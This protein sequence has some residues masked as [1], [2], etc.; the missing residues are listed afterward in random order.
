MCLKNK[1]AAAALC[2]LIAGVG[3][4]GVGGN[5]ALAQTGGANTDQAIAQ[6]MQMIESL[7]Q[8]IQQIIQLIAQLKPQETC[9]NGICRFGETATN[10][11]A[12]C[13]T[14]DNCIQE[15]KWGQQNQKCCQGL[16]ANYRPAVSSG[17]IDAQGL[18]ICHKCGDGICSENELP[19]FC[20]KDCD[21]NLNPVCGNKICEKGE[22]DFIS[23]P[24]YKGSC[25][26][27]CG[28]P[29]S[30]NGKAKC[31]ATGGVWKYLECMSGC[32]TPATK[33]D[34]LKLVDT[35]CAA[36]CLQGNG[37]ACPSGKTWASHEEGCIIYTPAVTCLSEGAV[38]ESNNAT[39]CCAGLS[40]INYCN[41]LG[42]CKNAVIC[43]AKCGDRICGSRENK[44]NCPKDCN[45]TGTACA[46]AGQKCEIYSTGTGGST[47][48]T[49]AQN[50]CCE[51]YYCSAT[52]MTCIKR[53]TCGNGTCEAGESA[54][55]CPADCKT[56]GLKNCAAFTDPLES[57][58][59]E[60]GNYCIEA[61]YPG[62]SCQNF[63]IE[64]PTYVKMASG[65][66]CSQGLPSNYSQTLVCYCTK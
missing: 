29:A 60:C 16:T 33:A 52:T 64:V 24:S 15:G 21:I 11:A 53:P 4:F 55:G 14:I 45:T 39:D 19:E 59:C 43:T 1:I 34:R 61:G 56:A 23:D 37:C 8:Q 31:S 6:M 13:Q 20:A 44:Y 58:D 2:A 51:G 10:C 28:N 54:N 46:G 47:G 66:S 40:K 35:L 62:G 12:D 38:K 41:D 3:I 26:A 22:A 7:K 25:P 18:F 9:G 57:R 50:T 49:I 42:E 27:D 30:D 63:A 48:G 36:V 32:G 65:P 17:S 5:N